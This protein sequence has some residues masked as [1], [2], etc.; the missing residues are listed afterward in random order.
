M[1]RLLLSVSCTVEDDVRCH[2]C[3]S[4]WI[5]CGQWTRG[6]Y[7]GKKAMIWNRDISYDCFVPPEIDPYD[8]GGHFP[9]WF[10]AIFRS[11]KFFILKTSVFKI[12]A[13]TPPF[14]FTRVLYLEIRFLGH[15]FW[16]GWQKSKIQKQIL[17]YI[18]IGFSF[19][20]FDQSIFSQGFSS[21]R[22]L[23]ILDQSIQGYQGSQR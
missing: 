23:Q 11:L 8:H 19:P 10:N 17:L 7:E 15:N 20:P 1:A 21:F 6:Y 12:Y 16:S 5:D 18:K 4:C 9:Y 14:F 3:R 22:N 2:N 13:L